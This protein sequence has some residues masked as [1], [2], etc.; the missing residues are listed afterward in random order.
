IVQKIRSSGVTQ[1]SLSLIFST[2]FV[3][4]WT[5]MSFATISTAK[6]DAH[7]EVIHGKRYWR[8]SICLSSPES[9]R[10]TPSNVFRNTPQVSSA[11]EQGASTALSR[12]SSSDEAYSSS[13]ANPQRAIAD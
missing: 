8:D 6:L 9:L 5:G 3:S 1:D 4:F 2:G 12:A 10:K 13:S 11:E 7:P